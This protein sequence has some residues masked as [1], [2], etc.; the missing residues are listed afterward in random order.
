MAQDEGSFMATVELAKQGS[1]QVM[2]VAAGC[3]LALASCKNEASVPPAEATDT[4]SV[5]AKDTNDPAE[6][7]M[8]ITIGSM[9][10]TATL[11]DN[12][13]VTKL[14]RLLPMTVEMTELNGNEKY[15]HL[16]TRLPADAISPGKIQNGDILLY[17]DNSLVLFYKTFKTSYSY[18]R[19]GR[20]DDPSGLAS[21]VGK[22]DVSVAF[23]L[24]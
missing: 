11:E 12:P 3:V 23:E 21:A 6:D 17:G 9:T 13:T 4:A 1:R 18:T 22:G 5:T 14:K 8:R 19:L 16:S 10:F 20:I 15:Y 7:K 24:R 2:L